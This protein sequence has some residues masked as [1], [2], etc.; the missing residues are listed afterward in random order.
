MVSQ[1]PDAVY[2]AEEK[3][4]VSQPEA[5]TRAL[6]A[7]DAVFAHGAKIQLDHFIVYY[8]RKCCTLMIS[9]LFRV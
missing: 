3:L 6:A 2:D 5:Q 8:T 4:P 1:D 9:P 7:F